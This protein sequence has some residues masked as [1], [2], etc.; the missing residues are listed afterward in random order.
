MVGVKNVKDI[1]AADV[2]LKYVLSCAV[3]HLNLL[4][5]KENCVFED[6]TFREARDL[7][8]L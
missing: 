4:A 1:N 2:V 3:V 6:C 8:K 7:S 5:L